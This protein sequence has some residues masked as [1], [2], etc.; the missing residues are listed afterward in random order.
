MW[1]FHFL[2]K[3]I[4]HCSAVVVCKVTWNND[5]CNVVCKF[6]TKLQLDLTVVQFGQHSESSFQSVT[7]DEHTESGL[8]WSIYLQYCNCFDVNNF[9]YHSLKTGDIM[10]IGNLY[11]FSIFVSQACYSS[12]GI[13]CQTSWVSTC[14]VNCIA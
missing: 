4:Q 13:T 3:P 6:Q 5:I 8:L 14:C 10:E 7:V 2:L 11:L 9:S 12:Y 1:P